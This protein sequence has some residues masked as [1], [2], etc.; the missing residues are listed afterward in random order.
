MPSLAAGVIE[1]TCVGVIDYTVC[2]RLFIYA[3]KNSQKQ[4]RVEVNYPV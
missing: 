4:K 3:Y 1:N 2:G